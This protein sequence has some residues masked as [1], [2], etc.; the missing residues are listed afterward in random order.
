MLRD[1]FGAMARGGSFGEF[2]IEH[3]NGG[4]FADAEVIVQIAD[5]Q[6]F[7][8]PRP[9]RRNGQSVVLIDADAVGGFQ[10]LDHFFAGFLAV[11]DA[12]IG[13]D[14]VL[15]IGLEFG[16]HEMEVFLRQRFQNRP[17]RLHSPAEIENVP[18]DQ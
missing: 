7:V 16:F 14:E 15:K 5:S 12:D 3:F 1:L 13:A 6:P 18:F 2:V 10:L 8:K 11:P 9:S 4:V 17:L